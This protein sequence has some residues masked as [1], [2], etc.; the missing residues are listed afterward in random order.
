MES[1]HCIDKKRTGQTCID[2]E[3]AK[4]KPEMAAD[5]WMEHGHFRAPLADV[6]APSACHREAFRELVGLRP[7]ARGHIPESDPITDMI[8]SAERISILDRRLKYCPSPGAS[9]F[10][11][12]S[13]RHDSFPGRP[14]AARPGPNHLTQLIRQPDRSERREQ[15]AEEQ[16]DYLRAPLSVLP[17]EARI[18]RAVYVLPLSRERPFRLPASQLRTPLPLVG[19][20]G[21]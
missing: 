9:A 17:I 12:S 20:S 13:T 11:H 16:I 1:F 15:T 18:T 7:I 3:E 14:T 19:C 21:R 5:S 6:D 8:D 2:T 4:G 10:V